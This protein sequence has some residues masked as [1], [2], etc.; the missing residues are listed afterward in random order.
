MDT[1]WFERGIVVAIAAVVA[2]VGTACIPEPTGSL[3]APTA[4]V[5][6][7]DVDSRDSA[8]RAEFVADV[9]LV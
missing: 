2:V 5:E 6:P 4:W 8:F 3:P 9:E 1:R 7:D